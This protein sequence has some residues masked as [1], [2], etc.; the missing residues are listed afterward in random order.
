MASDAGRRAGGESLL[1]TKLLVVATL[2]VFA[3]Q[4][5]V[6]MRQGRLP[7]LL[8]GGNPLDYLRFGSLIDHPDIVRAEPWRLL[9][10]VFVHY[11]ILHVGMNLYGL[12]NLA[13][14]AE[15]AVGTARF[16]IAYVATGI[17]GFATT[18]A[19]T[20]LTEPVM[21][22]PR[23]TAGASGAVFGIM[24]LVLGFLIRRRDPR[25]KGFALQAVLYAVLMGFA[26]N[27]MSS[28]VQVNN[29]AHIGGLVAGIAFG[30]AF[31]GKERRSDLAAN[32]LAAACGVASIG[33]LVMAQLSE[34]WRTAAGV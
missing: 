34:Y 6:G 15:P 7:A 1:A 30:F 23:Q 29:S 4:L 24:G 27:A 26:F 25:W 12:V 33:S 31:A 17:I 14:F 18:V 19:Y 2:L 11:G 16:V 32:V 20:A 21:L 8:G 28:S 3:G 13:R 9:S 10:A 22:F 5:A